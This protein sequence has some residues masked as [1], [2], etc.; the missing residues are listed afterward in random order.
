MYA[1]KK[2]KELGNLSG[3]G[4]KKRIKKRAG[5]WGTGAEALR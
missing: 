2:K 5:S 1:N 4:N 3:E